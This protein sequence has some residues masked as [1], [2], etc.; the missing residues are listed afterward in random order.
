MDTGR[1]GEARSRFSRI[2]R[3]SRN[4]PSRS[5]AGHSAQAGE[6]ARRAV[7]G[8][9][10]VTMTTAFGS[11]GYWSELKLEILRKYAVAYSRILAARPGLAHI[12][13]DAFA[14]AGM[15][16]SRTSGEMVLGS[17]LNALLV[18]PPFQEY[19]LIDL[20][21]EKVAALRGRVEGM[22]NVHVYEGDCNEVLLRVIFP[23]L[24]YED[25]QRG[26]VLLD[27]YV[28]DPLA[29]R[30]TRNVTV[31]YLFFASQKHTANRIVTDIFGWYRTRQG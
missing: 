22:P 13:V 11:I 18:E 27:D 5:Q 14:G 19:H 24:C 4:R 20:D 15:H 1:P 7:D 12:Y 16:L 29:M 26:L 25:Y 3:P 30:N 17:P 6:G 31:Y 2:H 23:R 28:P 8:A 9:A 10:A 21:G